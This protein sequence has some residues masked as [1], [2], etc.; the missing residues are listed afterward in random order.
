M[1]AKEDIVKYQFNNR[2][3]EEQRKIAVS[4]GKASGKARQE[5]ATMKK[6]LEELLNSTDKKGRLYGDLV[7]LGLIANAIDKSKGGNP[8]AYKTIAKL[9]GE[10]DSIDNVRETPDIEIRIVDNSNLEKAMYDNN[11]KV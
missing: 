6:R 7:H 9:L 2:T 10:M 1:V 4:G 5:K 11:D 8:E 3:P